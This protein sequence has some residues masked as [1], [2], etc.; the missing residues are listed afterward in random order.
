MNHE[1][2]KELAALLEK[3]NA[4]LHFDFDECRRQGVLTITKYNP[5][6]NT[7][8]DIFVYYENL[9][10]EITPETFTTR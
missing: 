10:M 7:A 4:S 9:A 2:I 5:D 1:F 8:K 6:T 3:H